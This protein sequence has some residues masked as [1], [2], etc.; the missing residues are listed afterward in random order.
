MLLYKVKNIKVRKDCKGYK[1]KKYKYSVFVQN[2]CIEKETKIQYGKEIERTSKVL[3][4][5]KLEQNTNLPFCAR[6]YQSYKINKNQLTDQDQS[7][8]RRHLNHTISTI[9]DCWLRRIYSQVVYYSFHHLGI[10]ASQALFSIPESHK[11]AELKLWLAATVFIQCSL[12]FYFT[13][14]FIE[15][16]CTLWQIYTDTNVGNCWSWY[17]DL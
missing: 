8:E 3:W 5:P 6:K 10:R 13:R 16:I 15:L 9:Y 4:R 2:R 17:V 7:R 1:I 14:C 11:T 12:C